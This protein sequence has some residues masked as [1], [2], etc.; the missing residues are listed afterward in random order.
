VR[1][2]A[3]F[4]A[5]MTVATS[6]HAQA[7]SSAALA[8]GRRLTAQFY[9]D[10]LDP[11]WGVMTAEMR[12][13]LGTQAGLQAFRQQVNDQIGAETRVV[14]EQVIDTLGVTLYARTA[15]FAKSAS[16]FLVQ[17]TLTPGGGISGFFIRPAQEAAPSKYLDYRTRTDLRLPFHGEWWVFWGGR[18]VQENYH[19]FTG[20][21]RFAYDFVIRRAGSSHTGSGAENTDYYCFGQPVLAPGGGVVVEAVDGI[22]DNPPSA[23]NQTEALGNHVILDHGDG[24]YSFIAH[25]RNGSLK[26][27]SGDRVEAGQQLGECGNSGNSSEPHVH[28]HLQT[29]ARFGKG[30]GLPAQFQNY[31]ADGLWV[32]RGEP[33]RGQAIRGQ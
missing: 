21:Q 31:Y 10:S 18:T 29:T 4:T 3:A 14:K 26:V 15:S 20:D 8:L 19:A 13:A 22:P 7:D 28:Y 30:D 23:M 6:A 5:L 12:Q 33:R 2:L 24:E 27:H 9:A 16:L 25:F 17:W 1:I 32:E 11:I